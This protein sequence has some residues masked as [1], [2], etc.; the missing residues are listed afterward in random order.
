[1]PCDL[2]FIKFGKQNNK[3]ITVFTFRINLTKLTLG[4]DYNQTLNKEIFPK[5]IKF[6]YCFNQPLNNN[7]FPDYLTELT[8][9]YHFNQILTKEI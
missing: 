8:F 5:K 3:L 2:T 7:S 4:W 1:M 9:G 6:G